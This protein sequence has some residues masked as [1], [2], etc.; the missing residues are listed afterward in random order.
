MFQDLYQ[1]KYVLKVWKKLCKNKEFVTLDVVSDED[2]IFLTPTSR[3][4]S[5]YKDLLKWAV[6]K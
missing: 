2:D 6:G 1:V 4:M 3:N 5:N